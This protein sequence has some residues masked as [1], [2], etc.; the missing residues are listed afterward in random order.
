M[1]LLTNPR[2]LNEEYYGTNN[3]LKKAEMALERLKERI[4]KEEVA[5]DIPASEEYTV[6][7]EALCKVFGFSDILLQAGLFYNDAIYT[8]PLCNSPSFIIS[9]FKGGKYFTKNEYGICFTKEADMVTTIHLDFGVMAK[10]G[11]N[12][13]GKEMLAIILHEIGHNFFSTNWKTSLLLYFSNIHT[14][15]TMIIA[16]ITHPDMY[17]MIFMFALQNIFVSNKFLV[18]MS[19]KFDTALTNATKDTILRKIFVTLLQFSLLLNAEFS[20]V[21]NVIMAIFLFPVHWLYRIT[22]TVAIS[23]FNLVTFGWLDTLYVGY[24][25]EKFSD[26]FATTY[27]YGAELASGLAKIT[28]YD[29]QGHSRTLRDMCE[30]D[31]SGI[32]QFAINLATLPTQILSHALTDCHPETEQRI[33]NQIKMLKTELKSKDLKPATKKKILADLNRLEKVERTYFYASEEDNPFQKMRKAASRGQSKY[34]GD[35]RELIRGEATTEEAKQWDQFETA[36]L[37]SKVKPL[38]KK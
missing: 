26:N 3:E 11:A 18:K 19:S 24:D 16:N 33:L 30:E 21:Y 2:I 20:M 1:R 10:E 32:T 38:K 23:V 29:R 35:V 34:G 7:K 28:E 25:N 12:I 15:L 37:N 5:V 17:F 31:S 36:L 6:L 4:D 8:I 22:S 13:T 9:N 27:G 14:I